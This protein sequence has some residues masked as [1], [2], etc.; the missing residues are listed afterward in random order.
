MDERIVRLLGGLVDDGQESR[1]ARVRGISLE[2]CGNRL[3]AGLELV[4]LTTAS[5]SS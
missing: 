1:Q 2:A 5:A 4:I 3:A